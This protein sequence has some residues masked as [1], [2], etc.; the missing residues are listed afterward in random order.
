MDPQL[1]GHEGLPSNKC[2][3]DI[4]VGRRSLTVSAIREFSRGLPPARPENFSSSL[5]RSTDFPIETS[6][7]IGRDGARRHSAFDEHGAESQRSAFHSPDV[8]TL[9]GLQN[10]KVQ[11]NPLI[12]YVSDEAVDFVLA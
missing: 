6:D 11:G 10:S 12:R 4:R 8:F 2:R 1:S 7:L 9:H 3:Q 5:E